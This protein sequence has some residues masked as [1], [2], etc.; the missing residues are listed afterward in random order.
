MQKRHLT[1]L[2]IHI[3]KNCSK[4]G[5]RKKPVPQ[6]EKG[7]LTKKITKQKHKKLQLLSNLTL[8]D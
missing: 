1:N 6:P 2:N 8:K 3:D 4:L 5:Y 7:H